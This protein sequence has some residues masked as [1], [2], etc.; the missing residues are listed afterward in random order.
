MSPLTQGQFVRPSNAGLNSEFSFST[1]G[2][3]TKAKKPRQLYYEGHI[4]IKRIK[5]KAKYITW[6]W[7]LVKKNYLNLEKYLF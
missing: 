3:L 7:F 6:N 2:C 1:T 5:K 4:T